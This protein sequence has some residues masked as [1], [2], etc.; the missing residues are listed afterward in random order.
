MS[1]MEQWNRLGQAWAQFF[2]KSSSYFQVGPF[3]ISLHCT[4]LSLEKKLTKAFD[5]LKIKPVAQSDLTVFLWDTSYPNRRLPRLDWNLI[6]SNGYRGYFTPPFYFHYFES[7]HALSILNTKENK[8]YY[9]VRDTERLPWWVSGSPLQVILHTWLQGK[10]MQLTH[11]AAISN[12]KD[13]LLLAGKGGSG[14]ST[15]TLAALQNGFYYIAEDYA[16]LAPG[17]T[18]QV[19]SIYQSAKWKLETRKRFPF[20][21]RFIE[22]PETADHEK[23]LI[24]YQ[25]I[26]PQQIKLSS[27]IK[28]IISLEIGKS[29]K[30]L[31][32]TSD[33]QSTLKNLMMSTL[34]QLP[35]SHEDTMPL[36]KEVSSKVPCY[37]LTLGSDMDAN[38]QLIGQLI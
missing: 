22:N 10:G 29:V 35:F 27:Q 30:P 24:Y 7:I 17:K 32:K 38:L 1:L 2:E 23:A 16:I 4:T 15:T 12:G 14:K 9:I 31:L 3:S 25:E 26:F 28:G 5:H 33:L 11:T 6:R 20:Y 36:L 19:F 8:A 18:P 13:A 37:H 21:D 34:A